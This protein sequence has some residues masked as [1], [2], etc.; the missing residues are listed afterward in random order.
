MASAWHQKSQ[1]GG[2]LTRSKID[3]RISHSNFSSAAAWTGR[4]EQTP[5]QTNHN[6]LLLY[7]ASLMLGPQT[8]CKNAEASKSAQIWKSPLNLPIE[9]PDTLE[10]QQERRGNMNLNHCVSVT[11]SPPSQYAQANSVRLCVQGWTYEESVGKMPG[12]QKVGC[13]AQLVRVR[14]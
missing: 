13:V 3:P 8:V 11:Y 9:T 6:C 7:G 12:S 1:Q 14:L 4:K 5:R 2:Q 10:T